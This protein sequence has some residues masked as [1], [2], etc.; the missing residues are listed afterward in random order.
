MFYVLGNLIVGLHVFILI[1]S[2]YQHK[3][4]KG[5]IFTMVLPKDKLNPAWVF[6]QW[7]YETSENVLPL[8]HL[9]L[10]FADVDGLLLWYDW[11]IFSLF[12]SRP[13]SEML[14]IANLW[15]AACRIWTFAGPEFRLCWIKLCSSDNH[16]T[17]V[18]QT[19][20]WRYLLELIKRR[21][22]VHQKI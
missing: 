1:Y 4:V 9:L 17:R 10:L 6:Q 7:A 16:Y 12:H 3:I 8:F 11:Q 15:H 19:S 14:T 2:T 13:L 22:K 20:N 21:A 18:P 5:L